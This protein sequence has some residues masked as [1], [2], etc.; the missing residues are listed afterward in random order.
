MDFQLLKEIVETPEAP[1][2]EK[3]IRELV[4]NLV[5]DH[6]DECYTD[7]IGIGRCVT[8]KSLDNR[9]SV[10]L[11][12]EALRNAKSCGCDFY[13]VFTAQEKVGIRGAR[14]AANKIQP[15]VGIALDITLAND[16]P[17]ISLVTSLIEQID[18]YHSG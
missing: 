16:L 3:P 4:E 10:Y 7:G 2:H 9:I 12:V 5:Q 14:V 13:A 6:A 1:G 18:Q 11:L 8:G 17:G 15:D